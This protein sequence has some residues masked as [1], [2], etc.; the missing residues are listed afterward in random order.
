MSYKAIVIILSEVKA[1]GVEEK[2]GAPDELIRE[3]LP[4]E[5]YEIETL[6]MAGCPAED[7]KK[8]LIDICDNKDHRRFRP[9]QA[10]Q[11][12][13]SHPVGARA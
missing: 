7:L 9:D 10:G 4:A 5:E 3:M 1:K 8:T 12:A 6:N 13:G 11:R 2:K